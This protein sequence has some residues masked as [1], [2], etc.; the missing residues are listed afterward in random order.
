MRLII[1]PD[2]ILAELDEDDNIYEAFITIYSL[3]GSRAASDYMIEKDYQKSKGGKKSKVKAK[4]DMYTRTGLQTSTLYGVIEKSEIS[5]PIYIFKKS[6]DLF[7]VSDQHSAYV[8]SPGDTGYSTE[9]EF[10]GGDVL[11]SEEM[12]AD[13]ITRSYP[14]SW[15]KEQSLAKSMFFLGPVPVT[16]SSGVEGGNFGIL[17]SATLSVNP[18]NPILSTNNNLPDMNFDVY[19]NAGGVG[20]FGFSAGAVAALALIDDILNVYASADVDYNSDSDRLLTGTLTTKVTNDMKVIYGK[21]GLY[22][23][24]RTV[25]WCKKMGGCPIPLRN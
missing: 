19:A 7:R 17:L 12:W 16:M 25:K 14:R 13:S 21:F 11:Y 20:G 24:Y 5:M 18:D 6:T 15:N 9:I 3:P 4:L 8:N 23:K 2:N 1:D 22:V 10:M